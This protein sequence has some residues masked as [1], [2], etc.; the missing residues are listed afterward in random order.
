MPEYLPLDVPEDGKLADNITWFARALRAAG[1]PVGPGRVLDAIRAVEAAGF[2]ERQDFYHVLQACFVSRPEH[3]AT[4][5]QIFRLFW[6]DPRYLEHMIAALTPAIRGVQEDRKAR[7]AEKRAA[8][9]LL[10]GVNREIETQENED[11]GTEI[12]IDA[13]RTMSAEERLRSLDFEQMSNDEMARAK[14]MLAKLS[15]P[16]KPLLSRRTAAS[17]RGAQVDWRQTLRRSMRQ[18]GDIQQVALKT[19]TQRWPN[20]VALCDISGSMSQYSRAVLHFLHAVSN[21]KGAGWAKVHAFTF[22]T[23]LTNITRHLRTRDVDAALAAAGAQAQDWEGGT[24]IGRCLH[25]F[26]RDW[27]RRVMG[28]GAVVLLIT[29]G[30]DRDDPDALEHEMRRLQLTARKV[31]WLNPLL[32]WDE[33]APKAR[34]IQAMLPHVDSFRAGHNIA[35][36]EGLAEA[37][38]R[39]DDAGEK[40]RLM[41]QL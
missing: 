35:A 2:T 31:I 10:D 38:S 16:V 33:F 30:L 1:L 6:R 40:A 39:P 15:L 7:A 8:E 5:Q 14:R 20:L 28:G 12:E 19:Q 13:S 27:S 18:G 3:R 23:R 34:G 11:G 4:F 37:I 29:D 26:N 17:P 21:E 24:R 32:R 22:G 36:L 25:E 41:A 9:A